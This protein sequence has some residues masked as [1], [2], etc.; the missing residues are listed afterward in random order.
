MK[1]LQK[2]VKN[3]TLTVEL[4]FSVTKDSTKNKYRLLRR[5]SRIYKFCK[6]RDSF[7]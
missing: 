7:S 5:D 2:P 6:I 3:N 4:S 1:N